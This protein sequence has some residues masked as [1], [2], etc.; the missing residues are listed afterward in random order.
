[1]KMA[2]SPRNQRGLTMVELLVAMVLG[3]ILIGGVVQIYLSNNQTY[4]VTEA[5]S[6]IQENARFAFRYL[7][8][9]VRMAGFNGCAGRF[10]AFTNTLNG[11]ATPGFLYDF[12]KS[13]EGFEAT[14]SGTWT[15]ALPAAITGAAGGSDIL[16]VRGTTTSGVDIT[17]QPSN[18]ADC[19][20]SA[21]YTADLKISSTAGLA[22]GDIVVAGNCSQASI[23]QITNLTTNVVHNT[24]GGFTPG[25]STK[26]LGACYAGN[27][28]LQKLST[29][30]FFV[31]N[32]PN[33]SPS[34]Y[35]QENANNPVELVDGIE[36]MQI[37][38]GVGD[39]FNNL[40]TNFVTADNVT[41][42]DDVIS[43]RISLLLQS[44][45]DNITTA[46]QSYTF[47]GNAT[48]AA[49]RRLRRSFTTTV[50][51]RNNLK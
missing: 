13:I 10:Q 34:L 21:S 7:T 15:P 31:M 14:G 28:Q 20:N 25:N 4:R 36:Q 45:D 47:D 1:M 30:V 29:T 33:G 51:L 8:K 40:V 43:V 16:V 39:K 18:S 2:N 49:D 46:P 50:A 23:F 37:T 3:L 17:G 24:G 26:N 11:A 6:R 32:N 19:K 38:Y 27:G 5:T 48:T 42:W 12:D 22:S 41:N 44:A 9:Q 35:R